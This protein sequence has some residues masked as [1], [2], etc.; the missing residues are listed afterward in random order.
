VRYIR[1]M[2]F[3]EPATASGVAVSQASILTVGTVAVCLAV[4][5]VL[6]VVPGP[7]LDLVVGAG[8]FI[9]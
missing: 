7:V 3:A 6:G 1:V 8:D 2:F 4:T 9:R 5:L